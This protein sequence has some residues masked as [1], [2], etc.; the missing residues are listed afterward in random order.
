MA[1]QRVLKSLNKGPGK[2]RFVFKSF[3]QRVEEVDVDVFRSLAPVKFEPTS[4]SSFFHEN[5]LRWRELNAAADFNDVYVELLPIVQTLPQLLLH[6]D[7][8]MKS[9][10][11][12]VR[13]GAFLSLEPIL[14][15]TALLSRDLREEFLPYMS[16]FFEVCSELLRTGGDQE[17][18]LLEQV[19]VSISYIIK[20]L[21]NFLAKDILFVLRVTKS[22]RYYHRT[23]VQDFIS[24]S[25]SYLLRKAPPKQLIKGVRRLFAEAEADPRESKI[26]SC[27]TLLFHTL[28][29]PSF[30]LH[31][32]AESL[33]H[34]LLDK[35]ILSGVQLKHQGDGGR[36]AV[37][38]VS[39]TF[40]MVCEHIKR[41]KL[42]PV[43]G[44]LIEHMSGALSGNSSQSVPPP[45]PEAKSKYSTKSVLQTETVVD[46]DASDPGLTT[47]Q[48]TEDKCLSNYS[49]GPGPAVKI[50]GEKTDGSV[51]SLL[52]N[53]DDWGTLPFNPSVHSS[54]ML[55][56]G[57]RQA[58]ND[59]MYLVHLLS[60]LTD[61]LEFRKGS[62]VNDYKPL[63]ALVP[64][65]LQPEV[66]CAKQMELECP[67]AGPIAPARLLNDG[68]S[69][70]SS[71][72]LRFLLAL[73]KSHA[74]VAGAS[75]GPE[76]IATLAPSWALAFKC[77]RVNCL[78]PFLRG[79]IEQDVAL[80]RIVASKILRSLD[81][82]IE[83]YPVDVLPFLLDISQK[84]EAGGV[85]L[86]LS[87]TRDLKLYVINLIRE[88]MKGFERGSLI[89]SRSESGG[90]IESLA[91]DPA[92]VWVA[93]KCLP[94]VVGVGEEESSLAWNYA[95]SVEHCLSSDQ[96]F[97]ALED[98]ENNSTVWECLLATALSSHTQ[99]LN[100]GDRLSLVQHVDKYLNMARM[101]RRSS[102]V[103]RS[104]GDL[105][106]ASAKD[107]NGEDGDET[108][109]AICS[110]LEDFGSNLAATDKS[111]RTMTLRILSYHEDRLQDLDQGEQ[112]P[113]KRQKG[114][115][116]QVKRAEDSASSY[117][118]FQQLLTVESSVLT[119]ENFRQSSLLISAVK[120]TACNRK[121]PDWYVVPLFNALVG[122]LHNRFSLLW[123]PVMEALAAMVEI[124]GNALGQVLLSHLE[125]TQNAFLYQEETDRKEE[126]TEDQLESALKDLWARFESYS[127][128]EIDGTQTG[129]LLTLQLR[130]LQKVATF[131][132]GRSRQLIPLFLK[133]VGHSDSG[134]EE[135]R[136]AVGAG[137]DWKAC[138]REWLNLLREMR[139][140]RSFFKGP[141]VK[142]ILL[143]RFLSDSDPAIQQVTLEVL[144]NWKD[145]YLTEN[146][147]H[148]ENLISSKALRE[149]LTTWDLSKESHLIQDEDREPLLTAILL[150]LF[151]KIMRRTVKSMGKS[152]VGVQR[153]AVLS[154]LARLESGELAP[155]FIQ[156]MKPLSGAFT[157]QPPANSQLGSKAAWMSAIEQ[158]VS[159]QFYEDVDTTSIGA[160]PYKRKLGFL[161]MVMDSLEIF[162]SSQLT[163]YLFA[164]LAIVFRLLE[165]CSST[166][167]DVDI[168]V[169]TTEDC[170][171]SP[172]AGS[173][174]DVPTIPVENLI[175]ACSGSEPAG[176][177]S[178]E[179]DQQAVYNNGSEELAV[180]GT[181]Q[182][183]ASQP[184]G[185]CMNPEEPL[186]TE[187]EGNRDQARISEEELEPGLP[188]SN[189]KPL[190]LLQERPSFLPSSKQNDDGEPVEDLDINLNRAKK[191]GGVREIRTLC[192]RIIATVI[193]KFQNIEFPPLF[194]DIFFDASKQSVRRFAA[195]NSFTDGPSALMQCFIA[196]SCRLELAPLLAKDPV[197]VPNILSVLAVK[198]ACPEVVSS[199][200]SFIENILDLLSENEEAEE[201][202]NLSNVRSVLLPHL[203]VLLLRLG[204]CLSFHRESASERRSLR[205]E[206]R[207]L[208]R[209]S[210]YIE[211]TTAAERLQDVLL[212]MLKVKKYVD[213]ELFLEVLHLL[214][215]IGPILQVNDVTKSLPVLAPLLVSVS[216]KDVRMAV[217]E[218]L[219][220]L[221]EVDLTLLPV[222]KL[223]AD[224]NSMSTTTVDEFDYTRRL[225]AYDNVSGSSFSGLT[226][227][228][229]HLVLSHVIYDMGSE[230]MSL[231]HRA[232]DCLQKYVQFAASLPEDVIPEKVV[233][234][235]L[236]GSHP[237]NPDGFVV[238]SDDTFV[239]EAV[240]DENSKIKAVTKS[241]KSLVPNFLL[242]HIRNAMASDS[243]VVRREWVLLL[244]EIAA[245]FPA[246]AAL[247][248]YHCLISKDMEADFFHNIVHLQV[249]RR[250]KAMMK[251]KGICSSS[252]FS[253]G[254]LSRIF[255]PLFM[256]SLF[257]ARGDKEGN[258]VTVAVETLACIAG[259]LF[260]EPY[261][262]FLMRSFR[263]LST[264]PDFQKVL[265]RLVC[266]I[267]DAFHFFL[268]VPETENVKEQDAEIRNEMSEDVDTSRDSS[269]RLPVIEGVVQLTSSDQSMVRQLPP[270]I[271]SLLRKR[272][273]PE[274]RQLM[275]SKAGIVSTPVALTQVKILK[276]MP[277]KIVEIELP[278]VVQT[279]INAL[280]SRS[281][282]VRDEA[283]AA[284][285]AITETL[286]ANYLHFVVDVLQSSLTKGFELHV[287]GYTLNSVLVKLVPKLKVGEIDYCLK[288]I[289]EVLEK[290][291]MGEVA[292]EKDVEA[293]AGKMKETKHMRSFES[294]KLLAQV[295]TFRTQIRALLGLV[296]RNLPKSLAPKVKS[297]LENILQQIALG[298]LHNK[299]VT[300]S[301]LLVI[302][303]AMI[304]DGVKE[305]KDIAAA[306]AAKKQ[307]RI[308]KLASVSVS[309]DAN[310]EVAKAPIPHFYLITEFALQLLHT[311][312]KRAKVKPS[313]GDTLAMLNPLVG[314]LQE[315][316]NSKYDG[317]LAST[318]KNFGLLLLLPLPAIDNYGSKITT[319]VFAICQRF[320]NAENP[321]LQACLN[322]L[323]ILIRQCKSLRLSEDQ[324]RNL[325]QFPI[326]VELE[327]GSKMALSLLKSIVSRKLLVPELYDMMTRVA[328]VMVTSYV[329]PVRQLCSQIL[330]Q[331]L[332]DYPL[333]KKRLQQHLDFF[334]TNVGYAQS[335]GREAALEMLHTVILKFPD[336]V[337]EEH[338]E[339]MFFPL[340]TRLVN[341]ES[342]QVRSMIGTILKVLMGHVGPRSLQ[343]MVDF[344]I[345]WYKG[346]DQRLWR[347]AA[348]VLGF[349]IE[350]MG[351]SFG[352]YTSD[353][354][355]R[356][357]HILEQAN[358]H[359][360]ESLEGDETEEQV[361]WQDA[362]FSLTMMEKLLQNLPDMIVLPDLK[363]LW[364]LVSSL[365]LHRHV[366]IRK[367]CGRMLG[368]YFTACGVPNK[369]GLES[370]A[371][372][373]GDIFFFHP[374]WILLLVASL[375][376]QLDSGSIDDA[377][378]EQ[379]VVI[380]EAISMLLPRLP[381]STSTTSNE[382]LSFLGCDDVESQLRL[383]R[384]LHMLGWKDGNQKGSHALIKDNEM[385]PVEGNENG[386]HGPS[387]EDEG[388]SFSALFLVF[389]KLQKI[390]LRV[391]PIQT[392]VILRWYAAMATRLGA[393]D[394][395]K[396]L[397]S[398]LIVLI[399]LTEGSAAK[400]VPE[401][402]KKLGDE[403]LDQLRELIGV[404]KFVNI[405]NTVREK[406]KENRDKRKQ[407][408]K[409]SVLVD[410]ER[411]AK[412]KIKMSAKRQAQKKRKIIQGKVQMG[413]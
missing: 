94:Y 254:A 7:S 319:L 376:Q 296:Q 98:S 358:P 169:V 398:M 46:A 342:N 271:L 128:D 157:K 253:Q 132:D 70:F 209:L 9:L 326:F 151:P 380:L 185:A 400:V 30:G 357:I 320:S 294:I 372:G 163:P 159:P 410:P 173:I 154:F 35:S 384:A 210:K 405:Y 392:K 213:H 21:M 223:I 262:G 413:L 312:L 282:A 117:Q 93:L 11:S 305:E 335:S 387:I 164:L 292:E 139:N 155:L 55:I 308:D 285:V 85:Q 383:S 156:L 152:G 63:F 241:M 359:E 264:K 299:S 411:N 217:S 174:A 71:E 252:L 14:S 190:F 101:H 172:S 385:N 324:L 202:D 345:S 339:S 193:R 137:K 239:E 399:K 336:T 133:F 116:G 122:I 301:D 328:Q 206:L 77:N 295:V 192:L 348:Q 377:M 349:S 124:H 74:Q 143:N 347:P 297:K 109:K 48:D 19:F 310:N 341:D 402:L 38:V 187:T 40:L 37:Q 32:Q 378:G 227:A 160:L 112:S 382:K 18:E 123:D 236:E 364:V 78:L 306:A 233:E 337:V 212:P 68:V 51:D 6:K 408:Q 374:S 72:V 304:E 90:Y 73:V 207:I 344:A 22:L 389:K 368:I 52:V 265:V 340:V 131:S 240:K 396:Y 221:G 16:K 291:I 182:P 50:I 167:T 88:S 41:D 237:R 379:L 258:L 204:G 121:I 181:V 146:Q 178:I 216:H 67:I 162:N 158:G 261:F 268:P 255:V 302:V 321:L 153:N 175:E 142:G 147:E 29:G 397:Q 208:T 39:K 165:T 366:W 375:C 83:D 115:D 350:V 333:S 314:L 108:S 373:R 214:R 36:V 278:Q 60:V 183:V 99:I 188:T 300:Q 229:T 114:N 283:R 361:P 231:R 244:R 45:D 180:L 134:E 59:Q 54:I 220:A 353:V 242:P 42:E 194:W 196:I 168:D 280:K 4:G 363:A 205:R 87:N 401:D 311:H 360:G 89:H 203:D 105:L 20:Y 104:V 26:L 97:G 225:N 145:K 331:F 5:L 230:D 371:L 356:C 232:S 186:C 23:F 369:E 84:L 211:D 257:E 69:E 218:T 140:A 235:G 80:V 126:S 102:H 289:L 81:L 161:H 33:L 31:S 309:S 170:G 318:L 27:C 219:I 28:K 53:C 276:L 184:A 332:L 13:I 315:C 91:R 288:Q 247:K 95:T 327:A 269:G 274:I 226:W 351:P 365:L 171:A 390:A 79:L 329:A 250:I 199:V 96:E 92:V 412:R 144:L 1:P 286:G 270:E 215:G 381:Q 303:Y 141:I 355:P 118:L 307:A 388:S 136:V 8:I 103:L 367:V 3:A 362:Y 201:E 120:V 176:T 107:R 409:I 44:C 393:N 290:D 47:G 287:L 129:T 238:T 138:L 24:E 346:A 82:L 86:N 119:H 106:D 259:Q 200:L 166:H 386:Q 403:V 58:E 149:E 125:A 317:V 394:I 2:K 228:Q 245:H 334:I 61:V 343:R 266:A 273:L 111:L 100:K 150:V 313:D 15:L 177:D 75:A 354:L 198:G 56:G 57:S 281:Q 325:L 224:L 246:D 34:L 234:H 10:L 370:A 135:A 243:L 62:R 272:V 298:F 64:V 248:E 127:L 395:E 256:N 404:A 191:G 323:I 195:E 49:S 12:R 249:H 284:L 66:L 407:A 197:L 406:G 110:L 65:L 17:P 76:I 391:H 130:T 279:V 148:L 330:L 179:E 25:V 251:F 260:W 275:V 316:L 267:L 338:A 222:A 322:V 352:R 277:E 293:I 263:L 189:S 43:W 113:A